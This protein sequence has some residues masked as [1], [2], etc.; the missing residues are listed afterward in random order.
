MKK[1]SLLLLLTFL[2]MSFTPGISN[3]R[4]YTE[5]EK[6]S[7]F[8]KKVIDQVDSLKKVNYFQTLYKSLGVGAVTGIATF[9]IVLGS[10]LL[11]FKDNIKID[12]NL[13]T[14]S[15]YYGLLAATLAGSAAFTLLIDKEYKKKSKPFHDFIAY[16]PEYKD[17]TPKNL[18]RTFND[19]YADYKAIKESNPQKSLLQIKL[20]HIFQ[21]RYP[22][23]L[24]ITERLIKAQD[25][26]PE[27]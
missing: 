11:F 3:N 16:F 6:L 17:L 1:N 18:L 24:D 15:T 19:I 2:V 4:K 25:C 21:T 20:W 27:S 5:Q 9:N 14:R 7:F 13:S 12:S 10:V 22:M 23:I 26:T 8:K